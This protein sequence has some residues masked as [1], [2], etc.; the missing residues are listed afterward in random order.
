MSKNRYSGKSKSESKNRNNCSLSLFFVPILMYHIV[1]HSCNFYIFTSHIYV[2]V[3]T[4]CS[5]SDLGV[6]S[7]TATHSM[8]MLASWLVF[9]WF[10][11]FIFYTIVYFFE[12]YTEMIS[13]FMNSLHL[14]LAGSGSLTA[15]FPADTLDQTHNL[16]GHFLISLCIM[17]VSE[18]LNAFLDPLLPFPDFLHF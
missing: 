8:K 13:L 3:F 16:P 9:Y 6:V 18:I 1:F 14:G 4:N 5:H 17:L 2:V 15:D 10:F 7:C 12:I 11:C